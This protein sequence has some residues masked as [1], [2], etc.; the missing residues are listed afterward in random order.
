[1]CSLRNACVRY[2]NEHNGHLNE[3]I[4]C[5]LCVDERLLSMAAAAAA[6]DAATTDDVM[7]SCDGIVTE[8]ATAAAA[9]DAGTGRTVLA[10]VSLLADDAA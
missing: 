6:A 8:D 3:N 1:M 4:R 2:T 10:I 5:E 7:V 9:M